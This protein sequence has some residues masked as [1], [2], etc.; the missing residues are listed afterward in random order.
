MR[1]PVLPLQKAIYDRI[2][3]ETSF[4][5]FD[6]HP[7][8]E[9]FPYVVLGEISAVDWSDKSKPGQSVNM[10]I[11]FWSRYPGKKETAEM[12]DAV[13]AALSYPWFPSLG[14]SFNPVFHEM[15]LSEIFRDI[16]GLTFHGV[17]KWKY[18]IEEL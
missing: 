2:S 1:S 18:L 7:E 14:A 17:L 13:T 3:G 16:D 15:E 6:N 4:H 8:S 11:H 10:T 9:A 12:M 5:V